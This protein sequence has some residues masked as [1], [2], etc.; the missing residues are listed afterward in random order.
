LIAILYT[1]GGVNATFEPQKVAYS[2]LMIVGRLLQF[3]F[4]MPLKTPDGRFKKIE[5]KI[6][7]MF[8]IIE[9][10]GIIIALTWSSY[11]S[12]TAATGIIELC[13]LIG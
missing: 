4:F 5:K 3:W 12:I 13:V 1:A 11:Y 9:G 7:L 2:S 6:W 8:G 10:I